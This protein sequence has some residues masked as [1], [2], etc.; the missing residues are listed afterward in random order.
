[1]LIAIEEQLKYMVGGLLYAPAVHKTIVR[2]IDA[3]VYGEITAVAFCLED[4]IRDAALPMAEE[5]LRETLL[6]AAKI[7]EERRPLIFVRIRTPEHMQHMHTYLGEAG[8]ILTGYILPKFDLSNYEEYVT[9]VKKINR[10]QGRK[11]YV[12]PILE[13]RMI[14]EIG[15]RVRTLTVL[16][17][18]ID[19]MREYV[20]NVRVGGNDFC[21]LYGLRRSVRQT[22]YDIGVVRDILVDILNVF[23]VDYIVS[24]PVWEYFGNDPDGDWAKGLRRELELDRLNGF[25]GKTVIHPSQIPLVAES[26]KVSRSDFEDA[27]HILHWEDNTLGVAKSADGRRM[28]EVNCLGRWADRVSALG[29]IYGIRED[30]E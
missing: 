17:K 25:V 29:R 11:I 22:I 3:G 1:M 7:P 18:V 19:S 4:T 10:N 26:L 14:A 20:L 12:M 21:N 9:L 28:S 30:F 16:K 15:S 13:S 5:A 23:S 6:E 27:E 8:Q 24:G 2:N